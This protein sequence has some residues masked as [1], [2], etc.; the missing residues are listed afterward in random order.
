MARINQ[1]CDDPS[2]YLPFADLPDNTTRLVAVFLL[3]HIDVNGVFYATPSTVRNVLFPLITDITDKDVADAL[4]MMSNNGIIKFFER[5]GSRWLQWAPQQYTYDVG[6]GPHTVHTTQRK[7]V[8]SKPGYIY[9]IHCDG[10][11][12]IGRA[13]KIDKRV[14]A[15]NTQYP[16]PLEVILTKHV[17]DM[18]ATERM[19]HRLYEDKRVRG[20]WFKLSL[21]DVTAIKEA[22]E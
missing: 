12:K 13:S 14:Y 22:L 1:F 21:E 5:G 11:Y 6:Y 7:G 16:H 15:F 10:Y 4:T 8:H 2:H 18:I 9:I 20:E 3:R 19:F 17:E